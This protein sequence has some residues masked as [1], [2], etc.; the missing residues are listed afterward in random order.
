MSVSRRRFLACSSAAVA[1]GAFRAIPGLAQAAQEAQGAFR[2]LRG[3]VGVFTL[4]GGTIGFLATPDAAIVVDT[5]YADTAPICLDGFKSRTTRTIDL[6]INTHHHADHTGGNGVFKPAARKILA[7][8]RV[9]EL[10]RAAAVQAGNEAQ[11][12]Y[13]D[14]TFTEVWREEIGREWVAARHHGPAHTGGDAVVTFERA[15]VVHMG[16]LV[17]NRVHPR[18]DRPAGASI[19]NWIASLGKVASAHE[20]DTMYIFGHGSAGAGI[21]GGRADLEHMADYLTTSLDFTRKGIAA[22]R[23]RE[24]IAAASALPGF[25]HVTALVPSLSLAAVLGVAYDELTAR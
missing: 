23:S 13:P 17:F 4:R 7:H 25:E 1:A 9:P 6:L 22:G 19:A 5:Q 16:D 3:G 21:T 20:R 18:I 24:E 2:D 14:A 8:A 12:V 11:Q 15:N 10:Q